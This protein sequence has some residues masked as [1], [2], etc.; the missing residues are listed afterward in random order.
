M[1]AFRRYKAAPDYWMIDDEE[2]E[3]KLV[4]KEVNRINNKSIDE[5]LEFFAR[6]ET[7]P[8][9]ENENYHSYFLKMKYFAA[10]V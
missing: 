2:E 3:T 4:S 6:E 1:T 10:F 9:M 5:N 8:Y 7:I